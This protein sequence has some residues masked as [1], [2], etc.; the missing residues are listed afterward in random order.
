[1]KFDIVIP[2]YNRPEKLLMCLESIKKQ[3]KPNYSVYVYFD[4]N[5][6]AVYE[7]FKEVPWITCKLMEKKHQ[8]FG[9]WNYHLKDINSDAMYYVCDD[10]EF[11]DGCFAEVER[12]FSTVKDYEALVGLNQVNITSG[13]GF[14]KFAM[15]CIGFGVMSRF[16]NRQ[17]FCPDFF[18]FHADSE[19]GQFACKVGMFH[20]GENAKIHHH[21]PAVEK[22]MWDNTHDLVRLGCVEDRR[23]YNERRQKN[24]LWGLTFERVRKD[25]G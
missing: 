20:Y 7:K 13:E 1:M 22:K 4:N 9:I 16:P 8:A 5:D 17:C 24:I 12:I 3:I 6:V 10:I 15:G 21:H 19:L 18:S 23:V 11:M 25:R 2:T 14:S